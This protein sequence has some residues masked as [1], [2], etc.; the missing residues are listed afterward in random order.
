MNGTHLLRRTPAR[1][2]ALLATV[3]MVGAVGLALA[4]CSSSGGGK[5]DDGAATAKCPDGKFSLTEMDYYLAPSKTNYVGT[6][7]QKFFDDFSA[8]NP[9]IQVKRESPVT[10]GGD[11]Y[12]SHALNLFN[13]GDQPDILMLDNPELGQFAAQGLLTPLEL[14]DLTK[15]INPANLDETTFDGKLYALPIQTNTLAIFYNKKLLQQA[16]ITE[17]PKTWD[18]FAA[19]AKKAT[20]G[21][22]SGFVFSGKAGPGQAAWQFYPWAWSNGATT[23]DIGSPA[24]VQALD[25]LSQMVADG[26]APKDVVNWTQDEPFQVFQAGKAAFLENGTWRVP[27]LQQQNKDLDWGVMPFPTRTADQKVVV[28]FGGEVWAV[29]KSNSKREAAAMKVL[30]AMA[31]PDNIAPWAK[32]LG[33]VPTV[34]SLW[35]QDP[36]S[37]PE[38]QVFVDELKNGRARTQGL[39]KPQAYPQIDQA[40]GVAIESALVGGSSASAA[41]GKAQTDISGLLKK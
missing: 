5:A 40:I 27:S 16:G 36:W 32:G 3:A 33:V 18:E 38:Y 23:T 19:D 10:T 7:A 6:S 26:S 14:G 31:Q 1:G 9:C 2:R 29:T 20:S 22:V 37:T 41:L 8:K 11:G 17:L 12:I 39:S 28:P 13:S 30:K 25:F 4:G 21:D 15:Q 24:G 35:N 34:P